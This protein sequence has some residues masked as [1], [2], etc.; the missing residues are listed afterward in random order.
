MLGALAARLQE[1][2]LRWAARRQGTDRDP[3][4]LHRRRVYILPTRQGGIFAA[5]VIAMLLAAMNYSNSLAFMLGFTLAAVWFVAMHRCHRNLVGLSVQSLPA[6]PVFVGEMAAFTVRLGN[7]GRNTRYDIVLNNEDASLTQADLSR[8]ASAVLQIRVRARRRGTLRLHRFGISTRYPLGLFRTWSWVHMNLPCVI[9]PRPA[10]TAPPIPIAEGE[11]G[12]RSRHSEGT[13]DFTGLRAYRPGDS[14][15][16]I[17]WKAFARAGELQVKQFSGVGTDIRWLDWNDLEGL[18][19]EQR[20]SILCRWV[21]DA[22]AGAQPYG[23]RLPQLVLEPALGRA[24]R[25]RCLEV[26]AHIGHPENRADV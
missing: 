3:F 13:E 4:V 6:A 7:S 20:L 8:G 11:E 23:L 18:E 14:P 10:E 1:K 12:E 25:D 17:A 24:H 5:V 21:L 19:T 22:E 15:R 26:L 9:Y 2:A 16:H